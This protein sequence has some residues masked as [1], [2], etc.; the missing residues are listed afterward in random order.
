MNEDF[1]KLDLSSIYLTEMAQ[2]NPKM[3]RSIKVPIHLF[4]PQGDEGPIPHMHVYHDKHLSSKKC[5]YIRLDKAEYSPHHDMVPLPRELHES[6]FMVLKNTWEKYNVTEKNGTVRL[7]TGYEAAVD[8][9]CDT[10]DVPDNI[11]FEVNAKTGLWI[12]PPYQNLFKK[13]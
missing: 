11:V 12:M 3:N 10:H 1:F 13:K 6:F 4:V 8:L 9:W 5:S 2:I 7:A